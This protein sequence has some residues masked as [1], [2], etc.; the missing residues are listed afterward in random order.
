[1][2]CTRTNVLSTYFKNDIQELSKFKQE[3]LET[4]IN[5]ELP[6]FIN[7]HANDNKYNQHD[8]INE[9]L[10]APKKIA[11]CRTL[12][13]LVKKID[14]ME[15]S[16]NYTQ[17]AIAS[18]N[19]AILKEANKVGTNFHQMI[20]ENLT[21]DFRV[22]VGA[23]DGKS[24]LFKL[25]SF[26]CHA[27]NGDLR[28]IYRNLT[29]D[30]LTASAN[31]IVDFLEVQ[32]KNY[33]L[34][35]ISP[36]S[37][38]KITQ[39]IIVNTN[40]S[41][42]LNVYRNILNAKK[43]NSL[44]FPKHLTELLK[45]IQQ[46]IDHQKE[47]EVDRQTFITPESSPQLRNNKSLLLSGGSTSRNNSPQ[48]YNNHKIISERQT[49]AP[50]TT[51]QITAPPESRSDHSIEVSLLRRKQS[52]ESIFATSVSPQNVNRTTNKLVVS[53]EIKQNLINVLNK[54]LTLPS[55]SIFTRFFS[56]P[57]AVQVA[58]FILTNIVD[59]T[60]NFISSNFNTIQTQMNDKSI[61]PAAMIALFTQFGYNDLSI[62]IIKTCVGNKD[63]HHIIG[64]I[65]K[66]N[67]N[68]LEQT[69]P[70]LQ[71][72]KT[73]Q[74]V[75]PQQ[76]VTRVN[77]QIKRNENGIVGTNE[78]IDT[79]FETDL[80]R[81]THTHVIIQSGQQYINCEINE[82][83]DYTTLIEPFNKDHNYESNVLFSKILLTQHFPNFFI[84]QSSM[85]P[86]MANAHTLLAKLKLIGSYNFRLE[87]N[88][89]LRL[90][91]K[92]C[93]IQ[94]IPI[95]DKVALASHAIYV[96]AS[97]MFN[98]RREKDLS[99]LK[100]DQV[101]TFKTLEFHDE[102]TNRN[103]TVR[104]GAIFQT[105][106]KF[107]DDIKNNNIKNTVQFDLD[108]EAIPNT[109]KELPNTT[110]SSSDT[111][112]TEA[113]S[114]NTS[115]PTNNN[116]QTS[117]H[118][119]PEFFSSSQF[120]LKEDTYII[121]E[122]LPNLFNNGEKTLAEAAFFETNGNYSTAALRYKDAYDL[123]NQAPPSTQLTDN[124]LAAIT[125]YVDCQI[126]AEKI[127]EAYNAISES[128]KGFD[129]NGQITLRTAFHDKLTSKNTTNPQHL[130]YAG[131]IA[132]E[133]LNLYIQNK[134][135]PTINSSPVT[136]WAFKATEAFQKVEDIG[137]S[138]QKETARTNIC[139]I[140]LKQ[141]SIEP[142]LEIKALKLRWVSEYL[143]SEI[144]Q[145]LLRKN[146]L[147]VLHAPESFIYSRKETDGVDV[148]RTKTEGYLIAAEL[149][150]KTEALVKNHNILTYLK[151]KLN[152]K[153]YSV[154]ITALNA[155]RSKNNDKEKAKI[156]FTY[157]TKVESGLN[158]KP[159]V[160]S[161]LNN[162]TKVEPKKS[163]SSGIGFTPPFE[164]EKKRLE[165]RY[166]GLTSQK[167]TDIQIFISAGKIASQLLK[168]HIQNK[169]PLAGLYNPIETWTNKAINHFRAALDS[170]SEGQKTLANAGICT[171]YLIK[172]H[173][174]STLGSKILHLK[175]ISTYLNPMVDHN[176]L[177]NAL[178]DICTE[179]AKAQ[180]TTD[181]DKMFRS[182]ITTLVSK[183]N[184]LDQNI[185]DLTLNYIK[186]NLPE[187]YLSTIEHDT[188][189]T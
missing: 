38:S 158:N 123:Y 90:D 124:K 101:I 189:S 17:E 93:I 142:D 155:Y 121:S 63:L 81:L 75:Q 144:D 6:N 170:G 162:N 138:E 39:E 1:M 104:L 135:T 159:E 35:A 13:L 21:E 53:D 65:L 129:I 44:F 18:D 100:V 64:Q 22:T 2:Q 54:A 152:S 31:A 15:H 86:F 149:I 134:I 46:K 55:P 28:Q 118:P 166:Q 47:H 107:A 183:A 36:N 151:E 117:F 143:T 130:I 27:N 187:K 157:S 60:R 12:Q 178:I 70:S 68:F 79:L 59:V 52:N 133:T 51:D 167:T 42:T 119:T 14:L 61:Q 43:N 160:E 25:Q 84:S 188:P 105:L 103:E 33:G 16:I 112:H 34:Q 92:S 182:A 20:D 56:Q 179:V 74:G 102:G 67:P 176:L 37:I 173:S 94:F 141:I 50:E 45:S 24:N 48:E 91:D 177:L 87:R 172:Y 41:A 139:N 150:V 89:F 165:K 85:P 49:I 58:E 175:W 19:D 169:T 132:H 125:K 163:P 30:R 114:G 88:M 161:G 8:A 108:D 174:C 106:R 72:I 184:E 131:L 164:A 180:P 71:E 109:N 171:V 3:N 122:Y 69:L 7:L 153:E 111:L 145:S 127:E 115:T 154:L 168:L 146:L 77:A 148:E 126:S 186:D 82:N 156:D 110:T 76:S 83:T 113:E 116:T 128:S 99:T 9:I 62:N 5:Q 137:S 40:D 97:F 29:G 78:P 181:Q 120:D 11:I 140:Y 26:I 32:I 80:N 66:S 98:P 147:S 96:K 136:S 95:L 4:F 23:K 10:S 185:K 57:P 73:Q